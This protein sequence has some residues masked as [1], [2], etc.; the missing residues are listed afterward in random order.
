[1]NKFQQE[2]AVLLVCD[3]ILFAEFKTTTLGVLMII[4]QIAFVVM[5]WR[6]ES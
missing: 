5:M 4:F 1:M 6:G 3:V 2:V